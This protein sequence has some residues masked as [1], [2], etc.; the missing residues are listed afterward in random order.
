MRYMIQTHGDA[1]SSITPHVR[2]RR[3]FAPWLQRIV[4]ALIAI[5]VLLAAS[6]MVYQTIAQARD[7]RAFPVPGTLVDVGGYR[8]HLH[9]MGADQSGPTVLLD[10]AWASSASQWGWVQPEVA[11]F[12][13]VV[14]FDRPGQGY[15]EAPPASLDAQQF[16]ADLHEALDHLGISG[17]YLLV[18]H[19]M[20]SLTS[21]AF[22]KQYPNHIAGVI[23]V[24]PRDLSITE[25]TEAIY[26]EHAP[27]SV[28]PTLGERLLPPL[29]ARLGIMRLADMLGEYVDQLPPQRAAEARATLAS[30]H[31]YDGMIPDALLGESAAHVIADREHLSVTPLIVLSGSEADAAFPGRARTRF[32]ELHQHMAASL[33]QRG[34][35]RIIQGA[36]HYTIV[37]DRYY[38]DQ[39]TAAIRD[40]TMSIE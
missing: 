18:G 35:H 2:R 20:G 17:P 32:N 11:G 12:A 38:A 5:V 36:D 13:R 28:E 14:S 24:D 1:D 30:T 40:I 22:A 16:A 19:S 25:F 8:L 7:R 15:S 31:Q 33:S 4:V 9:V 6:G 29:A 10:A 3:R 34:E 39:V 37:T 27:V 26:P 23:L 21:R